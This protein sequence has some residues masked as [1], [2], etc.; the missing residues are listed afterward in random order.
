MEASVLPP[1]KKFKVQQSSSM[2]T[3]FWDSQGILLVNFLPTEE[4]INVVHYCQTLNKL[5]EAVW[6]KRRCR[7][8]EGVILQQDNATPHTANITEDWLRE[9]GRGVLTLPPRSPDLAPSD[10]HLFGPLKSH[11]AGQRF[12]ADEDLIQELC[13]WLQNLDVNFL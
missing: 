2:A 1:A 7:L 9:Y 6:R 12:N 4:K 5:R 8:T 13:T 10:Y 3:V 11:L